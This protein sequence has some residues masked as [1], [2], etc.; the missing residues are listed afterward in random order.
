MDF[1]ALAAIVILSVAFYKDR[2]LLVIAPLSI[3]MLASLISMCFAMNSAWLALALSIVTLYLQFGK[4]PQSSD[5]SNAR[6]EHLEALAIRRE[7]ILESIDSK[8]KKI[9]REPERSVRMYISS[10]AR[11]QEERLRRI[12]DDMET[13]VTE[14]RK[15]WE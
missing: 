4:G 13:F 9:S 6:L 14:I 12:E 15:N 10:E 11:N 1:I 8:K 2:F 7:K 3:F 5:K